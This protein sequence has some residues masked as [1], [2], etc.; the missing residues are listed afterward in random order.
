MS[1]TLGVMS[2]ISTDLSAYDFGIICTDMS[3]YV[4]EFC[5]RI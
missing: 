5:P 1:F 3:A 4:F 2:V